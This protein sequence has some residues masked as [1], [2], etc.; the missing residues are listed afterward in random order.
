MAKDNASTKHV[1]H[2]KLPKKAYERA[3]LDLQAELVKLK[4][5]VRQEGERVVVVFEGRDAAGKG[6]V[7]KRIAE[8]LDPRVA[9]AS[10]L[11]P[12]PPSGNAPSGTSSGTS[13]TSPPPGR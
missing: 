12:P 8:Y 7:I 10:S 11:Y 3:L 1:H 13:P 9:R 2:T 5:W 4:E 6:G